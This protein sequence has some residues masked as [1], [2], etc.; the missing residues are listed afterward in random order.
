MR[1]ERGDLVDRGLR[2]SHFIAEG[3]QMRRREIVVAILN[4]MQKLDQ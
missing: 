4:E 1:I 3:A 2:Q